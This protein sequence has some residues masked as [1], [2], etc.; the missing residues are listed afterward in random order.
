[1]KNELGNRPWYREPWPWILMAGPAAVVVAGAVTMVLAVAT[2]D[3]LVAEDYYRRGIELS[4]A[5]PNAEERARMPA[6]KAMAAP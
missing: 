3:P 1:M 4:R 5:A 2:N 6:R